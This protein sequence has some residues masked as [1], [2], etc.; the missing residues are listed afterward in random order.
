MSYTHHM[1]DDKNEIPDN[2]QRLRQVLEEVDTIE[3]QSDTDISGKLNPEQQAAKDDFMGGRRRGPIHW[4]FD[5][6]RFVSNDVRDIRRTKVYTKT[7]ID[8]EVYERMI[9]ALRLATILLERNMPLWLQIL[10]GTEKRNEAGKM[11][12]DEDDSKDTDYNRRIFNWID[13]PNMARMTAIGWVDNSFA[14]EHGMNTVGWAAPAHRLN[15]RHFILLIG[16]SGEVWHPF[17]KA[18][19][20]EKLTYEERCRVYV[21]FAATLIHEF[22]HLIGLY[23]H[24]RMYARECHEDDDPPQ[25]LNEPII[26]HW[27]TRELG[28]AFENITFGGYLAMHYEHD[29]Y[30]RARKAPIFKYETK[31]IPMVW[32]V[33]EY[34]EAYRKADIAP[35]TII[36][37]M[38]ESTWA[39]GRPVDIY[40]WSHA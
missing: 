15:D 14:Y 32:F 24:R 26:S 40:L 30:K 11:I 2:L 5:K 22:A 8:D 29:A 21:H 16:C 23:R 19:D 1:V 34:G 25:L 17:K 27:P 3:Y 10:Y 38:Q 36:A 12:I 4:F 28:F 37:F 31:Q 39:G 18:T 13:L 6:E 9:P 20:W 35:E 33:D 7:R